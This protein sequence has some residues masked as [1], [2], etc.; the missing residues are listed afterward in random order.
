MRTFMSIIMRRGIFIDT[1]R[2]AF[3]SAHDRLRWGKGGHAHA[4]C[5]P[6]PLKINIALQFY[7]SQSTK[8][9]LHGLLGES[10]KVK[11]CAGGATIATWHWRLR[12]RSS[13]PISPMR[14][15]PSLSGPCTPHRMSEHLITSE[16]L[17]YDNAE[18]AYNAAI[19]ELNDAIAQY[20]QPGADI[21]SQRSRIDML[22]DK[23]VTLKAAMDKARCILMSQPG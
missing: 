19:Q 5:I 3:L 18:N 11:G 14:S 20:A 16:E 7:R 1:A 10:A 6:T 23:V 15:T 22:R 21:D 12:M 17:E 4:A 9:P 2:L 8:A 13:R